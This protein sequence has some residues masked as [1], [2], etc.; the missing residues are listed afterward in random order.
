MM[1]TEETKPNKASAAG[2]T[3]VPLWA[4]LVPV[5]AALVIVLVA[6]QRTDGRLH[7]WVFDVGEGDAILLLTPHGHSVLVDG[8]PGA[9]PLAEA[10]GKHLPFWQRYVD[11]AVLTAPKQENLMGLV[12]LLG[13]Y[14][15]GQVVQTQFTATD[16]LQ[17]L[18]LNDLKQSGTPVQSVRRGDLIGFQDEPDVTLR[19]LNPGD[20]DILKG[21]R[22][23]LQN[24]HSIVLRVEYGATNILLAGDIES[25]AETNMLLQASDLLSSQVLKV[26]DFGSDNASTPSFLS[27]VKPQV[28]IVSVA[29][30]NKPG[31]P[32]Q[33]VLDRLHNGGS[34]VYRTDQAGSVEITAEK[35]RFWV[36]SER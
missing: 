17:K 20:G 9:T 16:S 25:G 14:K 30:G 7:L 3:T 4:L 29:A 2:R 12:D 6:S 34:Q 5:I 13:R 26:A 10:V 18:W 33:D 15:L 27:A 35:D 31:Y 23:T 21:D 22:G 24:A 32:S 36:Q 8:G 11:I 1:E 19:V 28:S